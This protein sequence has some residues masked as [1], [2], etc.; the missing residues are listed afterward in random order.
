MNIE[1]A[2]P[3][4]YLKTSDFDDQGDVLL[5]IASVKVEKVGDDEKPILYFQERSKGLTLNKVNSTIISSAFGKETDGWV[6][7]KIF[8]YNDPSVQYMGEVVGGLRVRIPPKNTNMGPAAGSPRLSVQEAAELEAMYQR[9]GVTTDT[10]ER[11]LKFFGVN[12]MAH[13]T[14]DQ[15]QQI[16]GKLGNMPDV[17]PDFPE[18]GGGEDMIPF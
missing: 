3:S 2:F 12:Q 4:K 18:G 6:G 15:A 7:K 17:L 16:K 9:K 1:T 10:I 5:T 13:L 11:Q 8:V 14:R